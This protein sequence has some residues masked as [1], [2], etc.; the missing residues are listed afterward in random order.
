MNPIKRVGQ[1]V[2]CVTRLNEIMAHCAMIKAAPEQGKIYTV[3]GFETAKYGPGIHLREVPSVTCVCD[4]LKNSPWPIA[5]F[6]PVVEDESKTDISAFKKLL[7]P[8]PE[9][10]PMDTKINDAAK[11]A[12]KCLEDSGLEPEEALAAMAG[13]MSGLINALHTYKGSDTAA[14]ALLTHSAV[15]QNLGLLP[16]LMPPAGHA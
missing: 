3:A 9:K 6:R 16:D 1:K 15:L 14:L 10:T 8:T 11:L 2:I 4:R 12:L 5:S 13:M 7:N